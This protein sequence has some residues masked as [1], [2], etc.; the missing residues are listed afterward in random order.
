MAGLIHVIV[1]AHLHENGGTAMQI[2]IRWNGHVLDKR[3]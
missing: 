2:L 1:F 3:H